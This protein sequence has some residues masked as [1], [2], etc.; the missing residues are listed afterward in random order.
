MTMIVNQNLCSGCGTCLQACPNNAIILRDGKAFINQE[1]CS[2]CQVCIDVCPTGALQLEKMITLQKVEKPQ[3]IERSIHQI[4][5]VSAPE[6][7]GLGQTL[8]ALTGQYLMPRLVDALGTFLER[9]FLSPAPERTLLNLTSSSNRPYRQRRQ[10]Y[11]R[12]QNLTQ[13]GG[14]RDA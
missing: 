9:R 10:R 8:L 7:F 2:S 5:K 12:Y 4:D 14:K 13:K 11:R 1:T 3:P 6:R